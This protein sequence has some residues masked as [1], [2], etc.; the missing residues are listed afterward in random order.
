MNIFLFCYL[1]IAYVIVIVITEYLYLELCNVIVNY[2]KL[3]FSIVCNEKKRIILVQNKII[4]QTHKFS[5][6]K[7]QKITIKIIKNTITTK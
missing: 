6:H 3:V 5:M 2:I 1:C 7:I 4:S